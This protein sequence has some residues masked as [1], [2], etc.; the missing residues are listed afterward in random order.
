MST[1]RLYYTDSYTLA[2]E[3]RVIEQAVL[4]GQ[5]VVILDRSYFYPESGGQPYDT[6]RLNDVLVVNVQVRDA[7]QAV[8]HFTERPLESAFVKGLIDGGR[9]LDLTRHHSAQHILSA[10]LEK[11]A[12]ALTVSVHMSTESMII[13]VNRP[14]LTD[15]QLAAVETLANDIV[16]ADKSIRA[17]FPEPSELA[18]L[19]LR[20][21]PQVAGKLRVVDVAEGFDVTACGGTHVARTGEIGLIKITRQEK[22]KNGARLEFKAASRALDDFAQKNGIIT[23][24]A[25]ELTTSYTEIIDNLRRLRDENKALRAELKTYRE[26]MLI[27]EA[28]ELAAGAPVMRGMHVVRQVL[29][30]RSVEDAKTLVAALVAAGGILA[31]VGIPGEKAQLIFARSEDVSVDVVPLLKAALAELGEGRGGG[32]PNSAQGGGVPA[33]A[34][35]VE[36]SLDVAL[37]LLQG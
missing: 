30:G 22:F 35:R 31:L 26:E 17:W 16:L 14:P 1:E 13:A 10:A 6:G 18:S 9:R 15:P 5:P 4:N 34:G 20:K 19:N 12:G 8:L 2:F 37:N 24:L 29:S 27:R 3:A 11:A 21:L 32:R 23:T 25:A 7:D 36:Q 28:A 33:D